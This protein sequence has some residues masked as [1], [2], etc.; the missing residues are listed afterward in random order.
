MRISDWSSDVCSSDLR[1]CRCFATHFPPVV[2]LAGKFSKAG[3][4]PGPVSRR[5][6]LLRQ[7][8]GRSTDSRSR[9]AFPQRPC[10][11]C[12]SGWNGGGT[13]SGSALLRRL[14]TGPVVLPVAHQA[15]AQPV[16]LSQAAATRVIGQ[17]ELAGR[18]ALVGALCR[19]GGL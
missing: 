14:R 3:P 16:V 19:P 12:S 7:G 4:S 8:G 5:R 10:V 6:P 11:F 13:A 15:V 9:E 1:P 18:G 2:C 17:T